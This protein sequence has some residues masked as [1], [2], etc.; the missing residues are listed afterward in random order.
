MWKKLY[1][2]QSFVR[3]NYYSSI[4][5][6][7]SSY[8]IKWHHLKNKIYNLILQISLHE[9]YIHFHLWSPLHITNILYSLSWTFSFIH[10]QVSRPTKHKQ[11]T[12]Y[13]FTGQGSGHRGALGSL[14]SSTDDS[15]TP[16]GPQPKKQW[17]QCA[18]N[19]DTTCPS[20]LPSPS[21][22]VSPPL[23]LVHSLSHS[24]AENK[25]C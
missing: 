19:I 12:V 20:F 24:L 1:S 11:S 22:Y 10:G 23:P 21:R 9:L 15:A 18:R 3:Y 17:P 5:Y 25:E 8:E 14:V 13:R 2:L 16:W 4:F 7:L 6:I